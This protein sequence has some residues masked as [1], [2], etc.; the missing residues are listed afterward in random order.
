[1][2]PTSVLLVLTAASL[3]FTKVPDSGSESCESCSD[4]LDILNPCPGDAGSEFQC[5][6]A[7]ASYQVSSPKT[8]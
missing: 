2:Y 3:S 8:S 5:S 6:L 1:M 4:Q 7:I